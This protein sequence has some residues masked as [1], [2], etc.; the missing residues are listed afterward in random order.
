MDDR[1]LSSQNSDLGVELAK[2]AFTGFNHAFATLLL[3]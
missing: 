1:L 3:H 2:G